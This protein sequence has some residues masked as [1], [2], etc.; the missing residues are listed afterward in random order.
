MRHLYGPT[1]VTLCATQWVVGDVGLVP[2]VLPMGRPLENTRVYVLDGFLEPVPPGV[3]GE[4]YVA[5]TGV[6]RG[7]Q[8]RSGLTGERFVACPFGEPGGRMYRT[9][10]LV[11]WS[12]DGQLVFVG[13]A[14]DQVKVRGFRVEPGEVEAVLAA[15]PGVGQAV[16]V[17]REA[18][19]GDKRLTAYVVAAQGAGADD[20]DDLVGQVRAFADGRLPEYMVPSA[21]VVLDEL[22]LSVNGKVDR[23]ALPDP[24]YGTAEGGRGPTTAV[25]EILC[26]V[27]A[28]LLELTR[29]GVED[30][31]FELGGH[32]L[33]ATRL[34]SRV[35]SVFG[36]EVSV[37]ALFEAPTPA[38]LAAR[39]AGAG[40]AR[41]G[42]VPWERPERVPLSFAQRR[43]W[44]LAQLEGPSAT[45]NMAVALRL[46][47][48]LDVAALRAA[49]GDVLDR[50]EVL[51]TVFPV[52]DGEPYQEVLAPSAVGEVLRVVSAGE[53][54]VAGLVAEETGRGFDLA[55]EVPLRALLLETGVD[56]HV[57][58][59]VVHHVAGDGWSMGPL[60]RDI[61]VAYAARCAGVAPAWEPL[62]VQYADYALWQRELLGD[63]GDPGSV[64]A[65]QVGFWRDA[66]AGAPQ[67]L[68]LPGDRL[69]P[70]VAS[71]R[72][73]TASLVVPAEVHAQ[74]TGLAREQGVTLF[75]VVQAALAVLLSRLGA[76]EDIPVG[77]A[78]AGRTDQALDDLV[79][80]FVNTLVLRTDV[81]G[82]PTFGELLERVRETSLA[83]LEHQEVPFE[84]LV[85]VLA[86]DR[87]LARHPLFQVMLTLQNQGQA[88]LDLPGLRVAPVSGGLG[89]AKFD[90]DVSLGEVTDGE[91]R[92]VGLRGSVT[93]AADL[94]DAGTVDAVA[95]RLVKVLSLV[96]ADPQVRVG[97]VQVLSEAERHQVVA[98]WNDTAEPVP[99]ATWVELF[100]EQVARDPGAVAV[101]CGEV[102]LSY[103]EL[104]ERASRLAGVLRARGVGSESVVGVMFERS[105][106]AV[107]ALLG[108]WKAGGAYLFI[109]PS[110][111]E[112]RVSLLVAEAGPVCM[113]TVGSLTAG[114]PAALPV[115][116]VAV[117]DPAVVTEL[118]AVDPTGVP[119]P[120]EPGA[121]AYVMFTSGSTGRPK[122]VVVTQRDLAELVVDQC[123]GEPGRMLGH[124]PYEFDASV[125]ETWVTLAVG[126]AVVLAPAGKLDAG[127]LRS[128]VADYGLDR[129]HVTAGLLRM[130]VEED[131]GCFAGVS[132]VLTGGDVV[133]SA[134]VSAVL[135]AAPGAAVRQ[136]YGP[137]EITLC[138]TQIL[139]GDAD[140]VP[141][142]LPIGRPM[143]NTR[144]YLL[145]A[146]LSPVLPGVAGEL[147]VAG[148]GL[149]RGYHGRPDLTGE[150][151][152]ACPL[153]TPGERMYRTGDLARWTKDGQL[154]FIGRADNQV[155]VRGF[156]IEP[157]EV[158]AVLAAHP[159]VAQAVVIA[160]EDTSGDKRLTAYVVPKSGSAVRDDL[161]ARLRAYVGERLPDH[162]VPS[163]VVVLDGL[164]FSVNGKVDR[165]ALPAPEYTSAGGGRAPASVAEE[166]MCGVFADVLG[167]DRVGVEDS[168][169][170]LGGHSLL[171]MRLVS[172]VRSVFGVELGVRAL[173][174]APTPAGLGARIAGAGGAR[175]SL[176]RWE[177][178]ERVP[179]S[180]AQRRLWFLAQLEGPSATYNMPVALR[181]EGVLDVGA[182][183]A[184]FGDVLDRHEVLRTVFPVVDGEPYQEVLAPSAVGEVLRVVSAGE[185]EV[186]GLVA[187]ET[188]RG[189]DLGVEVPLR[190]LLVEV[191][192]GVHVLVVV[193]HHVAGDG[194]S[195][196]PLA[197]DISVAYA[198]R[199]D[200]RLPGWEP[201]PVQYADYTLWQ[202]E[203]LGDEGDPGSVLAGQVGFWR[204][205]LAGAPQELALP[206]DRSRP[207][208]A[209]HRGHTVRVEVPAEVHAGL[210]TLARE[211]GVTLFMVVQAALAVL[212]SRLG[213]GEDIPVGTAVA[214]RTD[215]A[216]D[217]LVGFFVNTLVL[218]TDVSGAPTFGELLERVRETSLAALEHQDVPFERLVEVLAPDRSLARH[219]LFQVML[220]VQNLGQAKLDLPGLRVAPT[221]VGQG[222][223]KF[224]LDV[225]LG[226][227]VD[228]EGRPG[229][230][231]GSVTGS[232]DL[233]DAGT[234][235]RVGRW[236]VRVLSVVAADP[237]VRV[238]Q[239][240]VLSEVER[241]EV[242]AG[243]NAA[244]EPVPEVSWVGL[245][246]RWVVRDSGAVAVVCGEE[247]LT[248]G[249]LDERSG[250]LAG[251]LAG[252]GV[253]FESVVGVV[254]ERSVDVVVALLGVWKAGGAYVFVD[255]S[256]PVERV[257]VVLAE[258]GPVCVVTEEALAGGLPADVGVPVVC[259]DDPAVESAPVVG[260]V[261]GDLGV[262]AYVMF[263]SGSSGVPKGVVVSQGA[264]VGLVAALGPVLGAGPGVGV[265]QFASFGFDGSV[266]DV[267]V[268]LASGGRLVVASEAERA[269]VGLLADLVVRE[270]VEVA[271]VVPSLLGVVDP[272]GVPGLGR[273]L[274]G[275]ELLSAEVAG[276]WADGRV[277]VNTYGPTE[278]TVMVTAGQVPQGGVG[279]PSVGGPVANA[280]LYVL[281]RF[282][283]PVPP[284]V[285]GELYVAGVQLARGYHQRPG[286]TGERFVACPFG[287][288]GE[289]MYRTGDLAR[290][291]AD[292]QLMFVGR[293]D[294]QV[295]VRGF[296]VEPAEVEAVLAAHPGV[297]QVV[298]VAREDVPGD[299]RL[300]AYVVPEGDG[301]VEGDLRSFTAERLPEYM[302]PSA[303]VVLDRLPLSANGKLDRAALP[304]PEYSSAGGRGP[305]TVAEELVCQVF[306]E[307]LGV[308]RVGVEDNF[309]ELGGHSLLAVSLVQRLREQGFGVSVRA[310]LVAPTPAGL[311]AAGAGGEGVV[312]VPPNGIPEQGVEVITPEM[313]PLVELTA[314]QIDL[315]CE[316]VEG[317]AANATDVYPLAPLQEGIF[318]HHLLAGPGE[319]DVYLV[320]MVLGFDSRERLDGFL[321]ALQRVVDRHDIYRTGLVWEGLPEPVQVVAR[322]AVVP[323]T[324]V[325]LQEGG[326]NP[327][328]ALLSVAG[329]WMDL[330]RAP[331]VRVHVAA[332]PGM[333]GR[334]MA[335]VQAHHLLQDHAA[336]EVVLGEVAA[337]MTGDGDRLPEPLPFRDFVAQAR[338]GVPRAEHEEFFAELLGDVTEP[339]L[340]FGLADARGDGSGVQRARL[341]VDDLLAS[342]VRERAH[343]LGVSPA[344]L[345]HVAWARVLASLAGRTDVVFGTV[346]LGR[347][348]AGM[349]ADRIPGPFMNTLPVRVHVDK[350]VIGAVRAMQAQLAGLLVHEHAPLALAQKASGVPASAPLFT[351]LLN[352]RHT[353]LSGE[354]PG[355]GDL[356]GID[357][358][359]MLYGRG[360][361][362]YPLALAVDDTGTGFRLTADALQPAD[363]ELVCG[364]MHTAVGSLVEALESAPG[365]GLRGL[366][367]LS[368]GERGRVLVGWNESGVVGVSGVVPG[369]F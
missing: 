267:A 139:V 189:F 242:V 196:G 48:V 222:A 348:N 345:F 201:L 305:A 280:R 304:A 282:L 316:S 335:L 361:T 15:H 356:N 183:S 229:G 297:G 24:E 340:P 167:L 206:G 134:A 9:G 241:Y 272:A 87:S 75:M 181:L 300:V 16:V 151:F 220:A 102:E 133:P 170:D 258:A 65:G 330:R 358:V 366:E 77:T 313:L 50:H 179:L 321:A 108:V 149:A 17:A 23:A 117:D 303:V 360:V 176:T 163:A 194:W 46:E 276:V 159:S 290:W 131:P 306:A 168:F 255:P 7:Y 247:R 2:G 104:D 54:E 237:Q 28:E 213:A 114:L 265:L 219:P 144:I 26:G 343:G 190:A 308:D 55:V 217:D 279:V 51:R 353:Q 11:R 334:W 62:P 223:A 363:P 225:S 268:A 262:A 315:I 263:T 125:L 152:V 296:R 120:T 240:E 143:D 369:L 257:G 30:H 169:F 202:R 249:E 224:D 251:V 294:D 33:L 215:Q 83:A 259:L 260:S 341:A 266:L 243:W 211:Q 85:E 63:E 209:S 203:L 61:S 221:S 31:F 155:K 45:Y 166:L 314:A 10:D 141:P 96:A 52:V 135:A 232:V 64:L 92:P 273:V 326:E 94:F 365:T 137:T 246:E 178:P 21:V 88:R 160:R 318:F 99:D 100:A 86:P 105:V 344:T 72:G 359:T 184:A 73:H 136:V 103:G 283:E 97:Q 90:L 98:G 233:F 162:L 199:C 239:V 57:L 124:G 325:T 207:A 354:H 281:D 145:D 121:A 289:R 323:V 355:D 270:G 111:P 157:G 357:G 332:E 191:G 322:R 109:N 298:V 79:G 59:V 228:G 287:G 68:V 302:V 200:G 126:G 123:W 352:Y 261:L 333:P 329:E 78:V 227:V 187:E 93:G 47:G 153:G 27:F 22:P 148:T 174:E 367:V 309:F 40:A 311:A 175:V 210:V 66:M 116:V 204:D 278:A 140:A 89:V 226:E 101:V 277:L 156:R 44:F 106:D 286:L 252:V 161:S 218:R 69:R 284:G 205:A 214:G 115:P 164:P 351:S 292:G 230:L 299:K 42:L 238:G 324:E 275:G 18:G 331:L 147:Y 129:V 41:V 336:L 53:G 6:A 43:L 254:L 192:V 4:L 60:A 193:V 285:A 107:V 5:G 235:E 19:L 122:G 20:D 350:D 198:A 142:V 165:A 74:L 172:R 337:F 347:M 95:E 349:G 118:A 245:F 362:N 188:G 150:R 113:V 288:A 154:V 32:S 293:A 1:E 310:L 271:S 38:A 338:L 127:V 82:D 291:T 56:V 216:L 14:D 58:V 269:D 171:A 112:E 29:V 81:S 307:V 185:G 195:M 177:R 312:E 339:T 244:V 37:R 91:G 231:R 158:E 34:V 110:Y 119:V 301:P 328:A 49:F 320:P 67:E 364:L 295:K 212:L 208:V 319:S 13:R 128:L 130:L 274:V 84:R 71:H 35:R 8:G 250:R 132:E 180:F 3:V 36:V 70:A 248:Y 197:Q 25:E 39:I 173:F 182:L 327:A 80:F 368:E 342:R 186:A 76:G 264:V 146:G 236:L 317:G 253:G 12:A 256:Y 138:A 346:L 234:V